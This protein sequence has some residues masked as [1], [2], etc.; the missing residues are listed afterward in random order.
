MVVTSQDILKLVKPFYKS[1]K[2][3]AFLFSTF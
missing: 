2:T 1:W 3:E